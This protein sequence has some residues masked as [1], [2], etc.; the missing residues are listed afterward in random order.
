MLI[1]LSIETGNLIDLSS[2]GSIASSTNP[3]HNYVNDTVIAANR[4]N[5]REPATFFDAFD[6]RKLIY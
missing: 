6:M 4:D 5:R 3:E 1:S 2:D